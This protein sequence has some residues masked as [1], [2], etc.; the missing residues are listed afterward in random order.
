MATNPLIG[1]DWGQ[2]QS[3]MGMTNPI[4]LPSVMQPGTPGIRSPGQ[5]AGRQVGWGNPGGFGNPLGPNEIN[6]NLGLTNV[7][8]GQMKN[9]LAPQYAQLMGQYGG[10]AG[11][12]FSQLMNFGSPFYRQKQTEAFQQGTQ[13]NQNAMQQAVQQLAARGMGSTPSGTTAAMIGGMQQQGAQNLAEQYLQNLF[14][15]EQMQMQGGQGLASLAQLFNPNQLLSGTSVGANIQP[16][17]TFFQNLQSVL[18]G[19]GQAM[20]GYGQAGGRIPGT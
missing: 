10:Q 11:D 19:I 17:S 18:G 7:L 20:G 6:R 15:N 13:Q 2:Q 12:F 1:S 9:A 5:N 3:P 14:Q 16:Q 8:A 4:N